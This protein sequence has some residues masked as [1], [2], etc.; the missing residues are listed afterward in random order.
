MRLALSSHP[1]IALARRTYMWQ[2][3]YRRYGDLDKREN[4]ERCLQALLQQKSIRFLQP[5]PQRIRK[6]FAQGEATYPRLFALFLQHFAEK[7]GK[8]RWGEQSGLIEMYADEILQA[9]PSARL[10]HM[11]RDP[12]NRSE[13]I[14][15]SSPPVFRPGKIGAMTASWN[16]SASLARRNQMRHPEQVKVV[17]YEDLLKRPAE[18]L[19][20][21][22]NFIGEDFHPSMISLETTI[23]FGEMDKTKPN[24]AVLWTSE[25]A[26]YSIDQRG[27]L[28]RQENAFLQANSQRLMAELGYTLHKLNL[29]TTERLGYLAALPINLVRMLT[30][31]SL[32][33][34]KAVIG[35]VQETVKCINHPY[36]LPELNEAAPA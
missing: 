10:I 8:N 32:E 33:A 14:L 3:F 24:P 11:V 15:L 17:Q 36:F 30:W 16:Y 23:P 20:D 12:R 21:V 6:E 1:N 34:R 7:Q 5:D 22:C 35:S 9:Y 4:F 29:S 26:D 18:T 25:I 13:E 31:S 27:C 2:R 28:T 19:K